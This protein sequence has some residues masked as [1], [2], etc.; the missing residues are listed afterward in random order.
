MKEKYVFN[1]YFHSYF[2]SEKGKQEKE[3]LEKIIDETLEREKLKEIIERNET[4]C[5]GIPFAT[6]ESPDKQKIYFYNISTEEN[7][8]REKI[9]QITDYIKQDM[10]I[11]N[12]M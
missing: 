4:I 1:F 10:K 2:N 3:E 12:R 5:R 8:F 7:R 6:I 11:L 9:E